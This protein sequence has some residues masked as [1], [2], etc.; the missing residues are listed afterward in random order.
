MKPVSGEVTGKGV[1]GSRGCVGSTFWFTAQF[2]KPQN[3]DR[4]LAFKHSSDSSEVVR[5]AGNL[6]E[7]TTVSICGLCFQTDCK[8]P[9]A[10][11]RSVLRSHAGLSDGPRW[12]D[13]KPHAEFGSKN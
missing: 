7:R 3:I 4:Q 1:T 6:Q 9:T 10:R 2:E 12:M 5:R 13:M 11:K 8:E